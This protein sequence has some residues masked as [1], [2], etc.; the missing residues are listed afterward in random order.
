[1][2]SGPGD[3]LPRA[4]RN[5]LAATVSRKKFGGVRSRSGSRSLKPRRVRDS[6]RP[7]VSM[8]RA[9]MCLGQRLADRRDARAVA[10]VDLQDQRRNR[11]RMLRAGSCC[12]PELAL[13]PIGRSFFTFSA[14]SSV[15]SSRSQE[16]EPRADEAPRVFGRCSRPRGRSSLRRVGDP[17]AEDVAVLV[18]DHRLGGGRSEIDPGEDSHARTSTVRRARGPRASDR[19]SAGSSRSRFL[20]F[21][22]EKYRGVDQVRSR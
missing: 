5:W 11:R 22:A 15:S 18:E 12:Q 10:L 2:P 20:T 21:A 17:A 6:A 9:A 7:S 8:H 13:E 4:G 3:A 19:A 1:M 16:R 14:S